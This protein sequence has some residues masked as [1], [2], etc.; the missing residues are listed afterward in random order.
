MSEEGDADCA[1]SMRNGVKTVYFP[2]TIEGEAY[3]TETGG[4]FMETS[5]KTGDNI[6]NLF[7]EIAKRMPNK[8]SHPLRKI[9]SAQPKGPVRET[10]VQ[11][12]CKIEV[13]KPFCDFFGKLFK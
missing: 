5:A 13:I 12:A 7:K 6:N 11:T 3:A 4:L 10:F 2:S 8:N 9:S 1:F